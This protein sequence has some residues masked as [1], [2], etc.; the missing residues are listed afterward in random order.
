MKSNLMLTG[1]FSPSPPTKP[2]V[3]SRP[4]GFARILRLAAVSALGGLLMA[5]ATGPGYVD[6]YDPELGVLMPE[7]RSAIEESALDQLETTLLRAGFMPVPASQPRDARYRLTL[8]IAQPSPVS[9]ECSIRLVDGSGAVADGYARR[10]IPDRPDGFEW[11]VEDVFNDAH[12][13]F[14]FRLSRAPAP[15][16]H[17]SGP[18]PGYGHGGSHGGGGRGPGY[19][20]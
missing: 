15:G 19:G 5:C 12:A 6:R 18:P 13:E 10:S 7:P 17:H 20:Y 1:P 2:V 3:P 8:R 9:L 16:G 4:A 11:A 14:R